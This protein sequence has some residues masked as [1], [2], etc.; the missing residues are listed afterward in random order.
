MGARRSVSV[1]KN[2]RA[3]VEVKATIETCVAALV[4]MIDGSACGGYKVPM[5][6]P[7]FVMKASPGPIIALLVKRVH[8]IV[9]SEHTGDEEET[10]SKPPHCMVLKKP[11]GLFVQKQSLLPRLFLLLYFGQF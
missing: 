6:V 3:T 4:C 9:I 10:R 1:P 5:M 7:R 11:A 8:E 2:I